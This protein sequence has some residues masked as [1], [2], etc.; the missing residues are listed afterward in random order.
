MGQKILN[1][2]DL[3]DTRFVQQLKALAKRA[4]QGDKEAAAKLA[5]M[6][7]EK[8]GDV[9]DA[10]R[11]DEYKQLQFEAANL[12]LIGE[13]ELPKPDLFEKA[14][15]KEWK[16]KPVEP[17]LLAPW[18]KWGELAG[19]WQLNHITLIFGDTGVGKTTLAANIIVKMLEHLGP[20]EQIIYIA[21]EPGLDELMARLMAVYT[22]EG[23]NKYTSLTEDDMPDLDE[24]E[25][26]AEKFLS[27]HVLNKKLIVL[28][29]ADLGY[30]PLSNFIKE[31]EKFLQ[32]HPEIKYYIF[33]DNWHD[34]LTISL[35]AQNV[36]ERHTANK[37]KEFVKDNPVHVIL[38]AHIR[39][40]DPGKE[41]KSTEPPEIDELYGTK[42]LAN[43][44]TTIWGV[45]REEPNPGES[46]MGLVV[47]KARLTGR[48]DVGF[49]LHYEGGYLEPDAYQLKGLAKR[50]FIS[51]YQRVYYTLRDYFKT[52]KPTENRLPLSQIAK[53]HSLSLTDVKNA[54]RALGIEVGKSRV[55]SH[56]G[57]SYRLWPVDVA[58]LQE[59]I[60][61]YLGEK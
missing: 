7:I 22:K 10:S 16:L 43:I 4:D 49:A 26:K 39:K 37:L 48:R 17:A 58:A 24:K 42:F 19:N 32:A 56:K 33:I 50:Q 46:F 30:P 38:L 45:W 5:R 47:R 20:N 35:S 12:D 59:A 34:L 52:H 51:E 11:F 3:E 9:W 8:K 53:D 41:R 61:E 1:L 28:E 60:A 44:A 40:R 36:S 31:T 25:R 13:V 21:A 27:E 55:S 18:P 6:G 14:A 57:K 29:A 2:D 23:Y 15:Y 54:I